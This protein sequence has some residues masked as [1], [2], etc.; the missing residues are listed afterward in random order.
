MHTYTE[1]TVYEQIRSKNMQSV[2]I[3][4]FF[5]GIVIVNLHDFLDGLCIFTVKNVSV[6]YE[7]KPEV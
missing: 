5:S 6:N 7:Q 3:S 1:R 2:V 4:T